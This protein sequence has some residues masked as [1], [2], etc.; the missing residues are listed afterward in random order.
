M[1]DLFYVSLFLIIPIRVQAQFNTVKRMKHLLEVQVNIT[2][3]EKDCAD[4]KIVSKKSLIKSSYLAASMPLAA[5][6]IDSN[7]GNRQDP[8]TGNIKFHAGIDFK[9][10]SD[11][12]MV[13]L[14]GKVSKVAYSEGLG[15]Y[16]EV[17]H[18]DFTTVYGHL[19]IILVWEGLKLESGTVVGLTGSTGRSTGDHLHFALKYKSR[20]IDPTPFLNELYRANELN[21]RREATAL[22]KN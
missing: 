9:G 22:S 16:V 13:I 21:F 17:A 8:L 11:S 14:P 7:Y 2:N 5:P 3:A 20:I 12:V 15:N 6:Y 18:N 10:A 1:K 19:S 4:Q